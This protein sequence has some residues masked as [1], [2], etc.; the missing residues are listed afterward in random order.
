MASFSPSDEGDLDFCL[1]SDSYVTLFRRRQL[2][3]ETTAWLRDRGYQV[4]VLDTGSRPG[5]DAFFQDISAVLKFPTGL[6]RSLDALN[7]YMGDVIGRRP[8]GHPDY[9]PT[10]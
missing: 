10:P 9:A 8:S 2:L 3:E 4:V 7:D 1:V 6:R 5:E